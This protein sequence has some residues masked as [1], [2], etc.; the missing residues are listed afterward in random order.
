[1]VQNLHRLSGTKSCSLRSELR[2]HISQGKK[3][4]FSC[5]SDSKV[6][7]VRLQVAWNLVTEKKS[8]V[9]TPLRAQLNHDKKS[10][11]IA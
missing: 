8:N 2:V 5:L 11:Q 10:L 7:Q 6:F 1:M 4:T 9:V 3:Q